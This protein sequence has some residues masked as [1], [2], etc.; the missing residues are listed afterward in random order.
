LFVLSYRRVGACV[1]YGFLGANPQLVSHCESGGFDEYHEEIDRA[2][3]LI[4]HRAKRH[5]QTYRVLCYSHSTGSLILLDYLRARGDAA[6]VGFVFNS[7]FLGWGWDT[8]PLQRL[9]LRL[10]PQALVRLRVWSNE[11]ELSEAGGPCAWALQFFSQFAWDAS[12]VLY[13][14]PVTVG[15]CRGVNA[16]LAALDKG[17][18]AGVPITLEPF[19]VLTSKGDDVLH[20]DEML[21]AAH[22]I[23]PS[24]TL[25][26]LTYARHDVFC[27][28]DAHGVDAA[29]EYLRTWLVANAFAPRSRHKLS[30]T[31]P[32]SRHP[33]HADLRHMQ[34][35]Q[36][37]DTDRMSSLGENSRVEF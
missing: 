28:H 9:L 32:V 24:R 13:N 16:A 37:D 4:H 35:F 22:A 6:F 19:L 11:T 23:G 30:A 17:Q 29:V 25:L 21:R 10:L 36:S 3:I 34:S 15:F 8:T 5:G 20:G 12:R 27:S 7:P 1:K 26:E 33:S 31:P 18:Q 2:L 14:V